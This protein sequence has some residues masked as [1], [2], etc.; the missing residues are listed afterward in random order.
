MLGHTGYYCRFI[1]RYENITEPL[2]NLLKKVE[3]FQWTPYC[4]KAFETLKE[5]INTTPI[6]IFPNWENEFHVHVDASCISLE[7]ILAHP[8]DGAMDHPIYFVGNKLS[9]AERNYMT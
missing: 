3:M 4:D 7:A 8:G 9:Q 1:K 2:E 5:N 6:L